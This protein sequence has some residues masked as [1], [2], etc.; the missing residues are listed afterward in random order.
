MF[1]LKT[2]AACTCVFASVLKIKIKL[3]KEADDKHGLMGSQAHKAALSNSFHLG[4]FRPSTRRRPTSS[5]ARR[6][7]HRQRSPPHKARCTARIYLLRL[8]NSTRRGILEAAPRRAL[9]RALTAA[10][11][12]DPAA[13]AAAA[14]RPHRLPGR[15]P[16]AVASFR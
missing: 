14:R 9:S 12:F 8:R 10:E 13:A 16:K 6:R 2:R 5:A 4:P 7:R 11:L 1:F 15:L 3:L